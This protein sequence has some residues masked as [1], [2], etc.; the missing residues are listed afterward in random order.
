M[1][2]GEGAGAEAGVAVRALLA[3]LRSQRLE[4]R[5]RPP[6]DN[7]G[8]FP[9]WDPD[10]ELARLR[11]LVRTQA[12]ELARLRQQS[13]QQ[14]SEIAS[15]REQLRTAR[16]TA[17]SAP[18][19]ATL[20]AFLEAFET[21]SAALEG[22]AIT[23]AHGE[24]RA[25]LRLRSGSAGLALEDPLQLPAEALSTVSFDIRP[26]PASPEADRLRAAAGLVV[27]VLADLQRALER[28]GAKRAAEALA[29]ASGLLADP[30]GAGELAGAI[31]PLAS[32]LHGLAAEVPA[33]GEPA[34]AV[35]ERRAAL[36]EAPSAEG[37]EALAG[38]LRAAEE[39]LALR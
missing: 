26:L 35:E 13:A 1:S 18:L 38:A 15:L 34:A 37:V 29:S 14:L 9:P 17:L 7:G 5:L 11:A 6:I 36:G 8:D 16:E 22:R 25:G 24:L 27:A 23:Q 33:L 20:A 32:A 39:A 21:G 12:A 19:L 28:L 30:P 4:A 2:A 3:E 31:G 10:F